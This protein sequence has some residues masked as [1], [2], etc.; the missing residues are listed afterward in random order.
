MH[1]RDQEHVICGDYDAV[2]HQ[3]FHRLREVD[4]HGNS[5][6]ARENILPSINSMNVSPN[7]FN[8]KCRINLSLIRPGNVELSLYNLSGAL[9]KKE[10]LGF[11]NVGNHE[12]G[13]SPGNLSSGTYFIKTSVSKY[14]KSTKILYLK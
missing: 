13:W 8:S 14:S 6:Q 1:E 11:L 9:V 10:Q 4:W 2:L 12:I 5:T 3:H 7:P